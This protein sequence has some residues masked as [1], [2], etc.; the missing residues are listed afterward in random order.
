MSD[1]SD[2]QPSDT[3]RERVDE[4]RVKLWLLLD[5]DRR[6]IAAIPLVLVFVSLVVL[7]TLDPAPLR[8][9]VASADP[10]E[11]VFQAF[12]T[13]IITGVTL[14]VTINQLVL[15]QELGAVGDQRER[16]AGA[17]DFRED[18]ETV[19]EAPISPPEPSSFLRA[20]VD[21]TQT[22]ANDLSEAVSESR[23]EQFVER[24]NDYIDSLTGNAEEVGN[25]LE[26]AQFG[27]FDLLFAALNYN[28]S[29]KIY[30]A[31]RLRHEH[32]DSLTDEADEAF[33]EL[34]EVLKFFGPAREHFKT[35]YFEW[36]LI[37][38]SRAMMYSAIPALIVVTGM[39]FYV[40]NP[41]SILGNTFGID[42]LIWTASA[43]STIAL[44]PFMLLLSF[45]LRIATVAKRTLSIGPFILRESARTEDISW[46]D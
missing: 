7:G 5:A 41:G 17:M 26:E 36:E 12:L 38:L 45:V 6:L 32:T 42:N 2:D 20:I 14:V 27:T 3:M 10:I 25:Q 13:A 21:V 19:L 4:S 37:N 15:S 43:A 46:D 11:T 30:E 28:Y 29:W 44:I 24:T 39:V 40:D 31:R 33:E 18:V 1:E 9:A 34:I 23:N 8:Q 35:L 16:M 22:R